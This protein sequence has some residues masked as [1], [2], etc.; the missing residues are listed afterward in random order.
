M[1]TLFALFSSFWRY[2]TGASW[3]QAVQW[4]FW[5]CVILLAFGG[6]YTARFQKNTLFCRGITGALKLTII[7]LVLVL[8]YKL[9]PV[10]MSDVSEYPFLSSSES[11]L[12]LINPLRLFDRNL[13]EVAEAFVRLYFLLFLVNIGGSFD[14][15]GTNIA[16]WLGSQIVSCGLAAFVYY[17]CTY[18]FSYFLGKLTENTDPMYIVLAI[19]LILPMCILMVMKIYFI[20][21]RKSGHPT[22]AKVMQFLTAHKFGCL[23][24]IT[25]FSSL[26]LLAMLTTANSWGLGRI[27]L[28]NFHGFAYLLILLMCSAT[29][30]VFSQY[31]T[32]R[33]A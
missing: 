12:T 16:S 25:H 26:T 17:Y 14:Y 20:V 6:I 15:H 22:Y 5:V 1:D 29:L 27:R 11:A 32:E 30:Y 18:Y 28:R 8:V 7:Y 4:P 19:C 24:S 2:L 23:F 33:K 3:F 9:A 10:F 13:G 21:F 31:Y